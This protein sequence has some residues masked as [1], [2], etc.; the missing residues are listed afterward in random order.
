LGI[1]VETI[2]AVLDFGSI[3]L[4]VVLGREGAHFF[5]QPYCME[6]MDVEQIIRMSFPPLNVFF[7]I[8]QPCPGLPSKKEE[9]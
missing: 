7:D 5:K 2:S 6:W 8:L 4:M 3:I 1:P 9:Q